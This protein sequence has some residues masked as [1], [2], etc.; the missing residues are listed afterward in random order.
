MSEPSASA[1]Q[2]SSTRW[3]YELRLYRG[4][5][6]GD[7]IAVRHLVQ[8]SMTLGRDPESDWVVIDP[9]RTLS[10]R[11]CEFI[12]RPG[13]LVIRASGVNG[14]YVQGEKIPSDV[15]VLL[16]T[17]CVLTLGD[18]RLEVNRTQTAASS[19]E[20]CA[21]LRDGR[22]AQER[23][24]RLPAP[25]L[26]T[27]NRSLLEAF[28]NGA[29]L[30][31][32]LLASEEPDEVMR[33]AGAIYRNMVHSVSELMVDRDRARSLYDLQRTK[34]GG[35][36]NNVFKWA[37]PQRL[38]VDLLL[39]AP[40]GFL[41]GPDA[42][43]S[44]FQAIRRHFEA[45]QVGMRSCLRALTDMFSPGPTDCG[46]QN[47]DLGPEDNDRAKLQ[48]FGRRHGEVVKQLDDPNSPFLEECFALAY[49]A[50]DSA[51]ERS[52]SGRS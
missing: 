28:C 41:S 21:E 27:T 46:A 13:G 51:L 24:E 14:A 40:A 43:Q 32:S 42:V 3:R 17:P 26:T 15:E 38:T 36:G 16:L 8:G 25:D 31:S 4:S 5:E 52:G 29:G 37:S 1:D 30:D 20:R 39:T 48:E 6:P 35:T 23:P 33:R 49:E 19:L 7:T 50:A 9:E 12:V 45:S 10:R 44:S 47:S 2:A 34:I 18:F 22:P 11:H